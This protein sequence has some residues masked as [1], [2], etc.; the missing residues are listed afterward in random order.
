MLVAVYSRAPSF[1]SCSRLI[2]GTEVTSKGSGVP[3]GSLMYVTS[4]VSS[5]DKEKKDSMSGVNQLHI[6]QHKNRT[7]LV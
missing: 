1:D 2:L 3:S 7:Y 5:A 6:P 4:F